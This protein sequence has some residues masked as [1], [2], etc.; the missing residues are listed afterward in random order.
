M[1]CLT[2]AKR[3]TLDTIFFSVELSP[4]YT[5]VELRVHSLKITDQNKLFA[6]VAH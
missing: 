3:T 2:L 1:A 4:K 5:F 6:P